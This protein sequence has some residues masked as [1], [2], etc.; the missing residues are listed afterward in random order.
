MVIGVFLSV[1]MVSARPPAP[2]PARQP[3]HAHTPCT[4]QRDQGCSP[5]C[6]RCT[7]EAVRFGAYRDVM[8]RPRRIRRMLLIVASICRPEAHRRRVHPVIRGCGQ[9]ARSRA[10]LKARP[11]HAGV[12]CPGISLLTCCSEAL[13]LGHVR[14]T[15]GNTLE[16]EKTVD[17][18]M[19][20]RFLGK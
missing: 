18:T 12:G 20:L 11:Y 6:P 13:I 9:Q 10:A 14:A 19:R 17:Q 8:G 4:W 15:F 7:S 3:A 16:M 5:A 2:C 1:V